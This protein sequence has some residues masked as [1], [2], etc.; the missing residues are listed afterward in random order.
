M[1]VSSHGC[2]LIHFLPAPAQIAYVVAP[3]EADAQLAHLSRT[4]LCDAVITEDSDLLTFGCN[5]LIYKMDEFGNGQ[6][7]RLE[8]IHADLSEWL[9]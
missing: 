6:E 5:R 8:Y 2:L 1:S 4:G 3:Y 7:V 9:T